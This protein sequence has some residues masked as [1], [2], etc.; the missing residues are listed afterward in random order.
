MKTNTI[1]QEEEGNLSSNNQ[2]SSFKG[3]DLPFA[4]AA[5]ASLIVSVL[6]W[7]LVDRDSGLFVGMWVP[8]IIGTWCV[9]RLILLSNLIRTL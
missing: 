5:L 1:N 7:F 2:T 3:V 9:V 4:I 8:S 6:L